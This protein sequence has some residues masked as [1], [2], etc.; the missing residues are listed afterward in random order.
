MTTMMK[1]MTMKTKNLKT[2]LR[3]KN[4]PCCK[5]KKLNQHRTNKLYPYKD[6]IQD[7]KESEKPNAFSF[8]ITKME[9]CQSALLVHR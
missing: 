4:L 6:L 1:T 5:K 7:I 2:N 3:Y 9:D 8:L